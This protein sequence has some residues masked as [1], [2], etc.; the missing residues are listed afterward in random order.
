VI[1]TGDRGGK[2]IVVGKDK[3]KI[4]I[5]SWKNQMTNHDISRW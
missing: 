3:K 4:Y 5:R 1:H 2:Y